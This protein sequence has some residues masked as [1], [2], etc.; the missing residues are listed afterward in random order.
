MLYRLEFGFLDDF[1]GNSGANLA[2]RIKSFLNIPVA[3]CRMVKVFTIKGI[4]RKNAEKLLEA[5]VLHDPI[6][7]RA[8]IGA[9]PP[10]EPEP[11]WF[12]EISFRPGVTDNEGNTARKSAALF[13]NIP[14]ED[15]EIHSSQQFR[16]GV[17]PDHPLQYSEIENI[18]TQLLCNPLIQSWRIMDLQTWQREGGFS[19]AAP[20]V[21]ASGN[22]KVEKFELQKMTDAEL[23]QESRQ[24]TWALSLDELKAI[25]AHFATNEEERKKFGLPGCPTDVEMEAIAQTWSEH[26]KHKIFASNINYIDA[27][28]GR[29]ESIHNLYKTCI[30]DITT[31]LR[32]KSHGKDYCLSVFRD[33]A[34]VISFINSYDA[35]IKVETH[36]SPSALDPYGGAL[37]GIVGVN[38]DPLGTGMGADLVCNLDVFCFAPPDYKDPLPPKIMHPSRIF[39]GVRKGVEDGGNKS[40]IPTVNGSIVFDRRFLGKPLVFCGTVGLIPAEVCGHPGYEKAARVDDV[41][42][43]AG[44]RIGKDGIHGATFSSEE[45]HAGSP[46]TAVQIGDPITQ[47]K[48]RDFILEARGRCLY[49][50]IT[51]NGAGGLSSS[52]GEMAEDTGGCVLDISLAPLKYNGLAPWE[53]LLSEAQERMTFAVPPDKLDEFLYLAS[54]MDV[55]ATALGRFT[56]SGFFD[57]RY[58]SEIVARLN[59]EFLYHGDP[60]LELEAVWKEPEFNHIMSEKIPDSENWHGEFL[61][62]MLASL[63]IRSKESIIRQYDHEVLGGSA[64]KPLCGIL[65]DGPND[66]AVI[67]PVLESDAGLVLSHG[68][69]PKYSDYDPYWMAANAI[70]EAVR[71]AVAVGGNPDFL[72][73]VDNFCWPDPVTSESNP[74]G[75]YK[76]AQLV[77]ACRGLAQFC[78]AYGVPCIS[79]KDSMKNDY[80]GEGRRI[81]IPPTLLFTVIGVIPNVTRTQ[82]SDFKKPGDRIYILGKTWKEM[83]AS[84]AYDSLGIKSGDIPRV[85]AQSALTRYQ[86]LHALIDQRVISACHDCSDGGF[87]VALAEMAIGGRLGCRVDIAKMEQAAGLTAFELLYS[88]SASRHIVTCAPE[89]A[90]LMEALGMWQICREIGIVT[91]DKQ[92]IIEAG[93]KHLLNKNVEDLAKAFKTPF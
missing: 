87:G 43:M 45:L 56:D 61:E 52:V 74:E 35:C 40:G 18:A 58:K 7:Q 68:I 57:I 16:F 11:A 27:Q 86:S 72:A 53:I 80:L 8:S 32:D 89:L 33:N 76:L 23:L 50:S 88:E 31:I 54:Q 65:R 22:A 85:D 64:I 2:N 36:N 75:A 21:K 6:L 13:L 49:H 83:A 81:S 24:H 28:T 51:D 44:G 41:I 20:E 73:G 26:C 30:R 15:I 39:A 37:T 67:R 55:E 79:G 29:K 59:M 62:K 46:V 48:L 9:L 70:D 93:D 4:S 10:L 17:L 25:A 3:F 78:L 38:R 77:K 14:M 12:C 84:E 90:S 92:V 82:T 19:P 63:N 71:N 91:E 1:N 5:S 66:A 69:C 60:V 34:G 47:K 42:V